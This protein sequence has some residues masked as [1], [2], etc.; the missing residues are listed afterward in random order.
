M[1]ARVL[2]G[3]DCG[4]WHIGIL[5]EDADALNATIRALVECDRGFI[6]LP[7]NPRLSWLLGDPRSRVDPR[8]IVNAGSRGTHLGVLFEP[9]ARIGFRLNDGEHDRRVMFEG[10]LEAVQAALAEL[11]PAEPLL[12]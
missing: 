12:A 4:V 1:R 2:M 7:S 8:Q 5:V 3:P 6:T 9:P 11:E 10:S